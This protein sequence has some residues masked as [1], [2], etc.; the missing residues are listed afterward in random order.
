MN[1]KIIKRC[2]AEG[3]TNEIIEKLN[4]LGLPSSKEAVK[5]KLSRNKT[6][7]ITVSEAFFDALDF[8]YFRIVDFDPAMLTE[9]KR[10]LRTQ[11][12]SK[13]LLSSG[14]WTTEMANFLTD[15]PSGMS[16]SA[17]FDVFWNSITDAF[18]IDE[19]EL[20]VGLVVALEKIR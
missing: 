14:Y 11:F 6:T 5:L 17:F 10:S 7:E 20:L 4:R 8:L 13:Y 12:K 18:C 3:S 2:L 1:R 16:M 19:D 9:F 15:S